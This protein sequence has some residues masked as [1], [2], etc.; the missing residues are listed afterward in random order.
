MDSKAFATKRISKDFKEIQLN[1]IEGVGICQVNLHDLFE[2]IV[3]IQ[4]QIGPYKGLIVHMM[5]FLPENFP[6]RPPRMLILPG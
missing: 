1:P 2:Y 5:L 6:S 3:N 4:I